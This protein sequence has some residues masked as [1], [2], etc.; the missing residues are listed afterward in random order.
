MKPR[1]WLVILCAYRGAPDGL[2]PVR[3]QK[4]MFL[5]AR[6][7]DVPQREQY[8]FRPYDYGP[9]SSAIY[10]DLDALVAKGIIE[11]H[12]VSG[13]SWFRYTATD[14]GRAAAGQCLMKLTGEVE[15]ENARRLFDIKQEISGVSFNQ[16]LDRVYRDHPDMAVNSVFQRPE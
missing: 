14:E 5:F 6:S 3:V 10:S 15:K 2:D 9:M 8:D 12:P 1:D 16:L 7:G 11:P 13:K 4:G